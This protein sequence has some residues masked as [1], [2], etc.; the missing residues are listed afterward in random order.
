MK[1][2]LKLG[3]A[4]VISVVAI[5]AISLYKYARDSPLR[6]SGEE[7]KE[8]LGA[9]QFDTVV[10]VRTDIERKNLGFY[11]GSLHIPSAELESRAAKELPNKAARI[12]VY[13]NTGQRARVATEKLKEMGYK[14]AV[15]IAEGHSA[16]L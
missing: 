13:C 16:L 7:A 3:I 4:I 11:P 15:Y 1:K 2:G 9:K 8:R 5:V 6:I 10:D 14:N 12:L